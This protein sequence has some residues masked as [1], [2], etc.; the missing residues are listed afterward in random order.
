MTLPVTLSSKWGPILSAQP[1]T[2]MG[3]WVV[4]V[5][6]RDRRQFDRVLIDGDRIAEIYGLKDIPFTEEDIERIVVTHDKW[7]W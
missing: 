2:G 6:L 7:K 4:S 1:E 3:Y 5:I